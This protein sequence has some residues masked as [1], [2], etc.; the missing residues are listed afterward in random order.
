[1]DL[2]F[3]PN[4][5]FLEF[6]FNSSDDDILSQ[7]LDYTEQDRES[8]SHTVGKDE[9][10]P[11]RNPT[12]DPQQYRFGM[13]SDG[14]LQRYGTERIPH[15][16]RKNLEWSLQVFYSWREERNRHVKSNILIL[17]KYV[18]LKELEFFTMDEL[19]SRVVFCVAEVYTRG[20]KK[21]RYPISCKLP[22]QYIDG[23]TGSLANEKHGG[24]ICMGP[25]LERYSG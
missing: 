15:N 18:C 1:M 11:I 8:P 9:P 14:D 20:K 19:H 3:D 25:S 10:K 21:R 6:E 5:R 4:D 7:V 12:A 16:T 13:V 2:S 23:L 22:F 17:Q 24:S